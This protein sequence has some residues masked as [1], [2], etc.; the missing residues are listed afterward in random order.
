MSPTNTDLTL[1]YTTPAQRWINALPVG[2]GR[3]GAM[4]FGG[5]QQERLQIN[6]DTL[7]SGGPRDWNNPQSLQVLPEIQRL[8]FAGHYAE[9]NTL[10]QQMQGPYTESY[11]PLGDL[12]LDF[13]FTDVVSAYTRDLD[14]DRA[15]ATTRYTVGG[16]TY[17]REV[18]SSFPDQVIVVRVT[19]DQSKKLNFSFR[20][21]SLHPHTTYIDADKTLILK[22]NVP[23]HVEPQYLDV[24]N[25]VSYREGEGMRFEAHLRVLPGEGILS[26]D[27]DGL[28]VSGAD[29]VVLLLSAGTSFAG[30]DKSPVRE[31]KDAGAEATRYLQAAL[32][33]PYEVL[34]QRHIED[35]QR[36][37]RRVTIDLGSSPY[38]KLPTDERLRQ[39]SMDRSLPLDTYLRQALAHH[40]PQMEALLFQ[41]GRYLL[42]ASSRPGTQPAN[43]QGIWND[44]I[45]PPW[46]SN[47]TLNINV[48]M[49]YWMA[50]TAN[51]SKCHL[52]LFD[53]IAGLSQTG[54]ETA[55]V[56]YGANGWVAHHNGDLWCHSAPVG[57]LRGNPV[58]ANWQMGGAWLC[59]HLWE[60]YLFSEDVHFLRETAYPLMK[61]AAAFLLDH[62][63]DDGTGHLVT[64]PSTSPEHEF[65][66][67]HGERVAVSKASTSDN[68][69]I[70]DLFTACI[71]ACRVLNSDADFAVQ[72]QSARSRLYPYQ[73]GARGQLQE[74]VY[75]FTEHESQHRHTSH[76]FGVYPGRQ[77][78]VDEAPEIIQAV[79]QTL[80]LRGDLSTGWSLAWKINLWGRL[81]DGNHAYALVRYLLT[82][83]EGEFTTE[84][85]GGGVYANLFDAHPPFQ[86]D[87]NFGVTAGMIEM[88][89]QSHAGY[90]HLLP[91]LPDAWA[92]GSISG[93]RARGGFEIDLEWEQGHLTRANIKSLRGNRCRLRAEGNFNVHSAPEA[94]IQLTVA[95]HLMEFDTVPDTVYRLTATR[96]TESA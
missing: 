21:T 45:R 12:L 48:Q 37:F 68:A 10:A 59:Q 6:E 60:H 81:R 29:S 25:P 2:N 89:L 40:D 33:K 96:V 65:V 51:L 56:N 44:L 23:A 1:W 93:L 78:I 13:P 43:L 11:Q 14:L 76:L 27:S 66:D 18:F 63:V 57:E 91:A 9:A 80:Y 94:D 36:L 92:K 35:H 88:L 70:W 95:D 31:G 55:R 20:L 90:I 24:E 71:D 42:I 73:I 4:V 87:G 5:I 85:A 67:S 28:R 58:W 83:D 72:L 54:R 52:P 41:Y 38:G 32:K 74:W 15:V 62:L 82:L 86:I 16:V 79:R 64:A 84:S 34:L 47:Y 50:E 46:S 39:C 75:D 7:W 3:L 8:I 69:I 22:G 17:T 30:F 77:L 53:L 49:N 26:E 61:G 19:C